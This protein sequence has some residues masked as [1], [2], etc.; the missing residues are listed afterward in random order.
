MKKQ[1]KLA[2]KHFYRKIY[3]YSVIF[4]KSERDEVTKVDKKILFKET[5]N[6]YIK[7]IIKYQEWV[8]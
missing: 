2:I 8:L 1:G 5:S 7:T 6:T 4:K 3:G